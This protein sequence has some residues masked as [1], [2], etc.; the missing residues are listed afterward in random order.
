MISLITS[1]S[2]RISS[3]RIISPFF[4]AIAAFA[5]LFAADA[6]AQN[7]TL[8]VYMNGN[9]TFPFARVVSSP[10][11]IDCLRPAGTDTNITTTCSASFPQTTLITLT[12]STDTSSNE[13]VA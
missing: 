6:Q 8:Y 1:P 3:S 2:F 12:Y 10:A 9:A 4:V 11:G 13:P 5:M 7:K